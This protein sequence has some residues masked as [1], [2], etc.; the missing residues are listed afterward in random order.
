[1]S[2]PTFI[3]PEEGA[4]L[5][6]LAEGRYVLE[7]GTQWGYSGLLMAEVARSV[8]SVDWHMGDVD[9]GYGDSLAGFAANFREHGS[10]PNLFPVVGL[11]Q[12]VL[13][14]LKPLQFNLLFHDAGH[15]YDSLVRDLDLALPLLRW[16][17]VV[18]V[19]DWGLFEVAQAVTP[20]LG[21]PLRVVGRLAIW[22]H[23]FARLSSGDG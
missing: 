8:V 9:S 12:H 13:P 20:R 10:P 2:I 6:R 19:H 3:S 15:D 16:N 18:A 11:T 17:A 5:R 1:M 14:L 21:P 7:L 22:G 4:E 23:S